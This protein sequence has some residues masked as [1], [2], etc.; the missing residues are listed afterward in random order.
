MTESTHQFRD[1]A[2]VCRG[3]EL[4]R[5]MG[6]LTQDFKDVPETVAIALG[7]EN[8]EGEALLDVLKKEIEES[9]VAEENED[10]VIE[11]W[12]GRLIDSDWDHG[13]LAFV[14]QS[15]VEASDHDYNQCS[16]LM[17]FT[18]ESLIEDC[19]YPEEKAQEVVEEAL[20]EGDHEWH[21]LNRDR[22]PP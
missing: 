8:K 13:D 18:V 1:P 21:F 20:V 19:G 16:C 14:S 22:T 3:E 12:N 2:R 17:D 7:Y 5:V 4:N 11:I 15:T 6:D 10:P 9:G